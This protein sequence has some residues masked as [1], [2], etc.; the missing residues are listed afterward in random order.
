[1]SASTVYKVSFGLAAIDALLAL[2]CASVGDPMC[3][4][5]AILSGLMFG[6][7]M[8]WLPKE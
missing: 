2:M 6:Y 4:A 5:Y 1:M 8:M 7:G 3:I